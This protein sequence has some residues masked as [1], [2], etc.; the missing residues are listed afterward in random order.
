VRIISRYV[1]R[2]HAGPLVF[3]MSALTSLLLLN[4]VAKQ[5]PNLVGKGL[6][7][8][9]IAEFILLS[10]PFTIA[11]TLPMAVLVATLHAFSRL[12]AD[13]EVTAF[14]ASGL[15][16]PRLMRPIVASGV[17]LSLVMIWFND[18][19]MPAANYRLQTLMNDI[20]RKKPTFS[21]RPQVINEVLPMKIYLRAARLEAGSSRMR[22]VTIFDFSDGS[23]R[24]TIRADS[25]QVAL[26]AD[27]RDLILALQH[28]QTVEVSRGEPQR[29]QRV[30]F[31]TSSVRIRSIGNDLERATAGGEKSDRERTVCELHAQLR[32]ALRQR[33]SIIARIRQ[34]DT[35]AAARIPRRPAARGTGTAYCAFWRMLQTRVA[36]AAAPPVAGA[37]DSAP[38]RAAAPPVAGAQ[39]SARKPATPPFPPSSGIRLG[40]EVID[41]TEPGSA[42]VILE[43]LK[44]QLLGAQSVIYGNQ[45]E[46]EK[47]FAI[48]TACVIFA[49]LGAPIAFR[50]PRGGVGMTIGVSLVVF[51]VYYVGLIVG[52]ELARRGYLPPFVAMWGTNAVL[53]IL[54]VVLTARLGTEG[55]THR[56]SE[57]AD[58][59]ARWVDR[60]RRRPNAGTRAY[61]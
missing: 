33:D 41:A 58:R 47:K 25:G 21:L 4:Y 44:L 1:L 49:L 39:D 19:V 37:Q 56:G 17:V 12:A 57:L 53:L 26:S 36:H 54:G 24:R 30:F 48:A 38:A 34:L 3:A 27:G 5:L 55:A 8:T 20:A 51:G 61:P 6:P 52:E 28:G 13:S 15:A 46:I 23:R 11:M 7:W 42:P 29:L 35:A 2:E 31:A 16:L 9:V 59:I 18:R 10:L 14:K 40:P 45:V 32:G 50:F 60:V 22:D 43:G